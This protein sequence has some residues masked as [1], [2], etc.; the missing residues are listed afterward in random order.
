[1]SLSITSSSTSRTGLS[2]ALSD[3]FGSDSAR[4]V[5]QMK[6]RPVCFFSSAKK[7]FTVADVILIVTLGLRC[8]V[9]SIVHGAMAHNAKSSEHSVL[10][11]VKKCFIFSLFCK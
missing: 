4:S 5:L 11:E 6:S 1:M 2:C 8:A 7:F 3:T 10:L 9:A